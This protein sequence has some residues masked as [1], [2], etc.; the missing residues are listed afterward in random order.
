MSFNQLGDK[1]DNMLTDEQIATLRRERTSSLQLQFENS[2]KEYLL[3]MLLMPE[4]FLASMDVA[5]GVD[6]RTPMIAA[7]KKMITILDK[8]T[9]SE[10]VEKV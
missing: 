3:P 6:R 5:L 2:L 4:D 8:S 7:L 9:M 1:P 10:L